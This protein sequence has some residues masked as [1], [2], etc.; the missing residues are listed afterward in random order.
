[1]FEEDA[2]QLMH[3]RELEALRASI[4][5]EKSDEIRKLLD[6]LEQ[7]REA[8][9][10]QARYINELKAQMRDEY[11]RGANSEKYRADLLEA[12][13]DKLRADNATLRAGNE[14]MQQSFGEFRA[15]REIT[16]RVQ[17]IENIPKSNEDVVSYFQL[18]FGDR[19]GFTERGLKTAAKC[20]INPDML[21][22]CL[23]QVA[24]A[25]VDLYRN[26]IKDV[27]KAFKQR[28]GWELAPTEGAET[29]K[30]A[31]FMNLRRDV[32][33]GREISVEP[34][35]KFPKSVRKTGA[36]YQRLYY[37]YDS[38]TRKIVVG[39]VGDHL[40]NYLSLSVH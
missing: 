16:E 35:I 17:S 9:A 21:W 38:Q 13:L 18:I 10:E 28:T 39:Y 26:G 23:Y 4:H 27:E 15:M 31:E 37:A 29:R 24:G 32:Y 40:D 5:M 22:S 11:V 25:L 12:Q 33:E 1:M 36:Q 8:S 14:A 34:H 7:E 3:E 20:D 6:M 30:I 2:R 19:L